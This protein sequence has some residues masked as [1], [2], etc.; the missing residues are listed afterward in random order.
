MGELVYAAAKHKQTKTTCILSGTF[1]ANQRAVEQEVCT[2]NTGEA[3]C[4]EP[5]ATLCKTERV[6]TKTAKSGFYIKNKNKKMVTNICMSSVP[7]WYIKE[8]DNNI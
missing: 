8:R 3:E 7:Y 6:K 4:L 2:L 5:T 1:P